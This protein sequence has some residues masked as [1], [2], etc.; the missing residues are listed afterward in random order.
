MTR[1]NN[2]HIGLSG[3]YQLDDWVRPKEDAIMRTEV[4][5]IDIVIWR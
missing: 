1:T 4:I 3:A 2:V 5:F